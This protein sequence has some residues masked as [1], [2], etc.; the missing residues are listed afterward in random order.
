MVGVGLCHSGEGTARGVG[1]GFE[2]GAE[3]VFAEEGAKK[4]VGE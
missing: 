1:E 2:G 4:R 3:A